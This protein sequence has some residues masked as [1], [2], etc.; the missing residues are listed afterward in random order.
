MT[1][2]TQP[3]SSASLADVRVVD[4]DR[5]DPLAGVVGARTRP[6][7]ILSLHLAEGQAGLVAP[8]AQPA[9][10]RV[11]DAEQAGAV[12]A[13]DRLA[14]E[15]RPAVVGEV[16][17]DEGAVV[18]VAGDRP[19]LVDVGVVVEGRVQGVEGERLPR[20]AG[21]GV[22]TGVEDRRRA[23]A[24]ADRAGDLVHPDVVVA[25]ADH[26]RRPSR[27]PRAPAGPGRRP[28]WRR[29][30]RSPGPSG[31]CSI[32][33]STSRRVWLVVTSPRTSMAS[34]PAGIGT[35]G[36]RNSARL[37]H[38]CARGEALLVLGPRL[39]HPDDDQREDD[40]DRHRPPG[41]HATQQGATTV[42]P[43]RAPDQDRHDGEG[44]AAQRRGSAP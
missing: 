19:A 18:V 40:A 41:G 6:R 42:G 7:S 21:R 13:V 11:A 17:A 14:V 12:R 38:C 30:C 8:V 28:R 5:A 29:R 4:H 44:R 9:G 43:D 10:A 27:R 37:C 23:G 24:V 15:E 33:L 1:R 26:E 16:V 25:V 32:A 3:A 31:T 39:G 34:S 36:P 20:A 2:S 22:V 35:A